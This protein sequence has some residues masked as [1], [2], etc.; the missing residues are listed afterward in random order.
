MNSE[1]SIFY[2]QIFK[3]IFPIVIQNL[4]SAAVSS[5][6]VLMLTK[7]GQS[8]LAAV[9]L[10]AQYANI[11]FMVYFGVGTGVTL[12]GAQYWG[13]NDI[14]AIELVE[15]IALRFSVCAGIVM[16][17]C[18]LTIP[19]L[20]MRLF[21][22]DPELI[23][24][25]G[26]YLRYVGFSYFCW[27]ITE[28]Y[29]ATLRSVERVSIV[30]VLSST[31]IVLNIILNALLIFGLFGFPKMGAAGAAL[32]TSISRG[33]QLILCFGVSFVSKNVKIRV[34]YIFKRNK[35]LFKD[36]LTMV[37]PA[38]VNDIAWGTAFSMYSVIL[39]HISTDI[40]AANS[41][42]GVVRNFAMVLCFAI[43]SATTI[44]LGKYI[45]MGELKKAEKD[46]ARL[47]NMTVVAGAIGGVLILISTY[48]VVQYYKLHSD[49]TE[50]AIKYLTCMLLINVIYIMGGAVNTTLIAGIFRA[51][52]DTKFGLICDTIDMWGYAVPLGF[53]S[54]FVLKLPPLVVYLL[55]CTDEFVKWPWVFKRYNSK[56]WVNNITKDYEG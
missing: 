40:V 47:L 17:I 49:M 6:D 23:A 10:A 48:P 20:M 24:I 25:G 3:L 32:A 22:S 1:R 42:V 7:V 51:G 15:G 31:A 19:E 27:S 5:V 38:M 33:I 50:Q 9:S 54:A 29:M 53:I 13:K 55:L 39:G 14:K 41:V 11:L 56:K 26:V 12:L 52:G 44:W 43:A 37:V 45:G 4:L 2:K 21:T 8:S 36:F 34:S 30:T 28:V 16:F 18:T 35:I 46:G